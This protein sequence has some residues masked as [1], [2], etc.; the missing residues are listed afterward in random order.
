MKTAIIAALLLTGCGPVAFDPIDCYP[1]GTKPD[2]PA[3][4]Q[5][6]LAECQFDCDG[7]SA[8]IEVVAAPDAGSARICLQQ[9][10]PESRRFS[11][12]ISCTPVSTPNAIDWSNSS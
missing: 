5:C 4:Y 8:W 12:R 10:L 9:L 3:Y 2:S 6:Q 1:P 11:T 7:S